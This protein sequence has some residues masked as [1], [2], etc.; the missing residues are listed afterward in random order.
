MKGWAIG[1]E[2]KEVKNFCDGC[3]LDI[4][5]K[6]ECDGMCYDYEIRYKLMI[7]IFIFLHNSSKLFAVH[8][9]RQ[10]RATDVWFC[11][12]L[13]TDTRTLLA[14]NNGNAHTY[15]HLINWLIATFII[16][17][18]KANRQNIAYLLFY[19]RQIYGM[20]RIFSFLFF[21]FWVIVAA[22]RS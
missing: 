14:E 18:I 17:D 12:N 13:V 3:V 10:K 16:Q 20:L 15:P 8:D 21:F 1:K 7:F 9:N 2:V 6:A 11:N 22:I 5:G 4:K 19:L